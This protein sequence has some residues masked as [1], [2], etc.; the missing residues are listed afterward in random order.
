[1]KKLKKKKKTVKSNDVFVFHVFSF[2]FNWWLVAELLEMLC[3]VMHGCSLKSKAAQTIFLK[4][5]L[6]MEQ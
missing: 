2:Y 3:A 4:Y 6:G 5:E 1:M